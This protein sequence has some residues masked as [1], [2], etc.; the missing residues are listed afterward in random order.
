MFQV[1]FFIISCLPDDVGVGGGGRRRGL[2]Y[3]G[4]GPTSGSVV[5]ALFRFHFISWRHHCSQYVGIELQEA[6]LFIISMGTQ[7]RALE[8]IF[9]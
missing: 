7:G 1:F 4:D 9:I 2:S 6:H 8:S 3:E 5:I